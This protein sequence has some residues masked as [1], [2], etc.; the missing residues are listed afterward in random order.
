MR[1]VQ[2]LL[3]R[4]YIEGGIAVLLSSHILSEVESIAGNVGI[5]VKNNSEVD[6]KVNY[7]KKRN[8]VSGRRMLFLFIKYN[9]SINHWL[10]RHK[11]PV[12]V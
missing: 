2:D 10:P 8:S 9:C 11:Q 4:L 3:K 6:V 7:E 1:Q 12:H 5:R